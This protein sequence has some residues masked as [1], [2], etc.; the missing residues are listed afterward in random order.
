[1]FVA[2][3]HMNSEISIWDLMI[4]NVPGPSLVL[5]GTNE[6]GDMRPGSHEDSV[7]CLQWNPH[8]K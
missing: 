5:G 6:N 3:G 1:M 7:M 4:L 8:T 2:V